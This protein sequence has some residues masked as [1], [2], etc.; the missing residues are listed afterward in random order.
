MSDYSILRH[1]RSFYA[2]RASGMGQTIE[3]DTRRQFEISGGK[4]GLPGRTPT[5]FDIHSRD[6]K[7]TR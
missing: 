2:R 1:N 6:G 3:S 5:S 7:Q 4:P